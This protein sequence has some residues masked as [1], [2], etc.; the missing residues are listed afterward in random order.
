MTKPEMI[1]VF[2]NALDEAMRTGMYGVIEVTL[3]GGEP[4]QM[5]QEKITRLQ[6]QGTTH[7]A[8]HAR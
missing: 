8:K 4:T 1:K 5:R 6:A 2:E 3:K 7:G